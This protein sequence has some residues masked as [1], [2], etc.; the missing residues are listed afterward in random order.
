MDRWLVDAN[1]P[2]RLAAVVVVVV[3]VVDVG[4][5]SRENA[6]NVTLLF[7]TELGEGDGGTARV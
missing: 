1:A 2:L 7:A 3:V 4:A 5:L 6:M